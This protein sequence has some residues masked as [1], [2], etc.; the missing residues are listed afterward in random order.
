M[1]GKVAFSLCL[2]VFIGAPAW[3][4][5]EEIG[6][7]GIWTNWDTVLTADVDTG[8][9]GTW[10]LKAAVLEAGGNSIQFPLAGHTLTI[11]NN[12][13]YTMN[14]ATAH[15]LSAS[16]VQTPAFSGTFNWVPPAAVMPSGVPQSCALTGQISGSAGGRLFAPFDVDLDRLGDDGQALYGLPWMEAAFDPA[17][18]VKPV[19]TCP[20]A[21]IDVE[22]KGAAAVLPIGAGRGSIT[23]NGMVVSYDYEMDQGLTT[24]I[25]VSRGSPRLTYVWVK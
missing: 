25:M 3:S 10:S 11:D 2:S 18:A 17:L 21:S 6:E 9:A 24:L 13:H 23:G 4:G 1:F 7:Q 12:G 14:Y 8:W 16:E 22:I 5:D 15:M 20:G 19:I